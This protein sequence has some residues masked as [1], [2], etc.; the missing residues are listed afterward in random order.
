VKRLARR[1]ARS[2]VLAWSTR[3]MGLLPSGEAATAVTAVAAVAAGDVTARYRRWCRELSEAVTA[4]GD[5]S[6]LDAAV[7]GPPRGGSHETQALLT[8]LPRQLEG[9]ELAAA[10]LIVASLDP[11]L[12]ELAS[13]VGAGHGH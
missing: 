13:P 5:A 7:L 10:R 11:D 1:V 4:F 12:G 9:S 8:A 6:P 3:E 2:R